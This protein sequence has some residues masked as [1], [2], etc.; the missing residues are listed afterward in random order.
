M[1]KKFINQQ[2]NI[3]DQ[4]IYHQDNYVID[5]NQDIQKKIENKSYVIDNKLQSYSF[6]QR[7]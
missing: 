6:D 3:N 5:S 2:H 4:N 7:Q 1:S